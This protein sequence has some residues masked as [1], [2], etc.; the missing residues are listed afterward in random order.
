MPTAVAGTPISALAAGASTLGAN[1]AAAVKVCP[2][3]ATGNAN[4]SVAGAGGVRVRWSFIRISNARCG[5]RR[6]S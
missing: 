2:M 1:I 4:A 3:S 6:K 5:P